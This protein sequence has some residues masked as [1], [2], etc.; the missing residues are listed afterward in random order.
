MNF[1]KLETLKCSLTKRTMEKGKFRV[2]YTTIY[3]LAVETKKA[4]SLDKVKLTKR[5]REFL[6]EIESL[7]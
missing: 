6:I 7:G 3:G 5:Q 1:T 4:W 2:W